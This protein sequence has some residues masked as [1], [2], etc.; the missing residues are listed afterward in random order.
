L[1]GVALNWLQGK[2]GI[3]KFKE[4]FLVPQINSREAHKHSKTQNAYGEF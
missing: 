3:E 4:I 2:D 1:E